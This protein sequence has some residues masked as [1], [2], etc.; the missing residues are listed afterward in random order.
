MF[1]RLTGG[2]PEPEQ[3][4]YATGREWHR[5]CSLAGGART[6]PPPTTLLVL[7]LIRA[8]ATAAP[9]QRGRG[10]RFPRRAR[11][12]VPRRNASSVRWIGERAQSS[13]RALDHHGSV[14]CSPAPRHRSAKPPP[15]ASSSTLHASPGLRARSSVMEESILEVKD[16]LTFQHPS[17]PRMRRE[18]NVGSNRDPRMLA[19]GRER[20]DGRG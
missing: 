17:A 13:A 18:R 20:A 9:E 10:I 4:G 7:L 11:Q 5:P 15:S 16:F 2:I 14:G 12:T 6:P 3:L 8:S 19:R 1:Q